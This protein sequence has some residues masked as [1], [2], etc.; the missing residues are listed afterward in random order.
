MIVDRMRVAA[1]LPDYE[2]GDQLGAGAFGLVL[3]GRHRR[4]NRPVAIK[5]LAAGHDGTDSGS[6]TEAQLLAA[7]DHPHVVRV[8]DYVATD[9]L[10]LIVMELLGGGTLTRHRSGMSPQAACAVGLAAASALSYA[11]GQGVLHRDI[12]TDNMLFDTAGLLKVT[13]FGIAK[14]VEGSAVTASQVAG[15]PAYMAPEQILGGRLG[16]ATDLYALGIVLYQLLA[17]VPPFDPTLPLPALWQHHLTTIPAPPAGVP[18]P[19]AAVILRTL[20][21]EPAAR[22]PSAHAFSL[23]L[24]RATATVYG[25]GWTIGSGIGLRLDDDIRAAASQLPAFT[26]SPPPLPTAALATPD[27]DASLTYPACGPPALTSPISRHDRQSAVSGPHPPIWRPTAHPNDAVEDRPQ[28]PSDRPDSA[29]ST[30]LGSE[31]SDSRSADPV[32]ASDSPAREDGPSRSAGEAADRTSAVTGH[33]HRAASSPAPSTD[34]AAGRRR[35]LVIGVLLT[36]LL[37][38]VGVMTVVVLTGSSLPLMTTVAGSEWLT[39]DGGPAVHARFADPFG[40][41]VDGR[42]AL[43][44]A[45]WGNHRV[46]RVNAGG[47]VT[48]VAG[49]GTAGFSGDGGPATHAQLANPVG[50]AVDGGGALY[51]TDW[52]N[53]RV[54][55]VGTE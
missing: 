1:A 55:R 42:G 22:P 20:A 28:A 25:P 11:H 37:A 27:S 5:I 17:G 53:N 7:L 14:L 23:D 31:A 40:V 41:A 52:G 6:A 13:D 32:P 49:T 19:I 44:I 9:D 33:D 48:T 54:R 30:S 51:I 26:P 43:Y 34:S 2:L 12:K 39:G 47:V 46:R 36:A 8:H 4:L 24:A 15:T 50:V 21:K 3:A 16:P 35:P 38:A 18:A 10:H 45:D 29:V